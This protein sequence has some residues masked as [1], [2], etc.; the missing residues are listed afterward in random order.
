MDS[1]EKLYEDIKAGKYPRLTDARRARLRLQAEQGARKGDRREPSEEVDRLYRRCAMGQEY[2]MLRERLR[3]LAVPSV[4]PHSR[5]H[6]MKSIYVLKSDCKGRD[7]RPEIQTAFERVLQG[8]SFDEEVVPIINSALGIEPAPAAEEKTEET[9]TVFEQCERPSTQALTHDQRMAALAM[10]IELLR[11]AAKTWRVI[12]EVRKE[13]RAISVERAS[14][15]TVASEAVL[16]A[17]KVPPAR[18]CI[19]ALPE[20][21][22]TELR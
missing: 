20:V 13:E 16:D 18:W 14:A 22:G 6:V 4:S 9:V 12:L 2:V 15:L 8:G 17:A 11:E 5:G 7:R 19:D 10:E 21:S 1:L 3:G